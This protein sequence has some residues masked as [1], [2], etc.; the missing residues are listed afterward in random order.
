MQ[1]GV[2]L[3]PFLFK[4]DINDMDNKGYFESLITDSLVLIYKYLPNNAG[5]DALSIERSYE[6]G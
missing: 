2:P 6:G 5:V 3:G 1:L 4:L